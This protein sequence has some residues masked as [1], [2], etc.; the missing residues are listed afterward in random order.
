M[1]DR[2]ELSAVAQEYVDRVIAPGLPD[3]EAAAWRS[4]RLQGLRQNYA[5]VATAVVAVLELESIDLDDAFS[6]KWISHYGL[7]VAKAPHEG[8]GKNALYVVLVLAEAR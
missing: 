4:A 2:P 6:D 3:P 7:G 8:L 5:R 1:G